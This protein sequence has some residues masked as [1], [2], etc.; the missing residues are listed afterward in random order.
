MVRQA[1]CRLRSSGQHGRG[2]FLWVAGITAQ[3][4]ASK[5]GRTVIESGSVELQQRPKACGCFIGTLN[6]VCI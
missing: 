6:K 2:L 1:C 5:A 4:W 3:P